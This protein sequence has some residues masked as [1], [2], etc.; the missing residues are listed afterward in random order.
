MKK[1]A[2]MACVAAETLLATDINFKWDTSG[3]SVTEP[4]GVTE[5]FA[6]FDSVVRATNASTTAAETIRACYKA[7]FETGELDVS[8]FQPGTCLI[9]R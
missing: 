7:Y 9:L 5:A 3:R 8:T 6:S 4:T 1:I 2:F